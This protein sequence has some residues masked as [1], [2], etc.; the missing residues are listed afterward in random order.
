MPAFS[1]AFFLF[2]GMC[3]AV[4]ISGVSSNS[5]LD[6]TEVEAALLEDAE[7]VHSRT[8][9]AAVTIPHYLVEQRTNFSTII[10][11]NHGQTVGGMPMYLHGQPATV[12]RKEHMQTDTHT[13][14]CAQIQTHPHIHHL[15]DT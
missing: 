14:A 8:A 3:K 15:Y 7:Q 6:N 5:Q 2:V 9:R 4:P 1:F 11:G 10:Q 13:R 12:K